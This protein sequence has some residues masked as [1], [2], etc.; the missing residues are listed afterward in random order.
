MIDDQPEDGV[1][2]FLDEDGDGFG[3][4]SE[5]IFTCTP[6]SGYIEDNTDCDDS[7]VDT[8][9]GSA[10]QDS[11]T[12]CM[13]DADGDGYGDISSSED[14]ASGLRVKFFLMQETVGKHD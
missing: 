8:F 11:P 10:E 12:A 13:K 5:S 2:F 7:S 9:P 1:Y 3:N 6:P 4:D 14:V